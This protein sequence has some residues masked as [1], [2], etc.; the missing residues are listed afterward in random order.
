[1]QEAQRFLRYV[2]PGLILFIELIMYL[3]LSGDVCFN[4]LIE[5]G[6]NI[7]LAISAFLVTGAIG[8]LLGIIYNN[9]IWSELFAKYAIDHRPLLNEGKLKGWLKLQSGLADDDVDVNKLS[10]RRAWHIAISYWYTRIEMSNS[11]KGSVLRV[12]RLSDIVNGLGTQCISSLFALIIWGI[13]NL[14]DWPN[15]IGWFDLFSLAAGISLFVLHRE[16]FRN[17]AKDLGTIF[18]I[19]L[20]NDLKLQHEKNNKAVTLYVFNYEVQKK[21]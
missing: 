3:L 9:I 11:I 19:V 13:Y 15:R 1:M 8:F 14:R 6:D 20:L 17:V 5:L 12:E 2:L 16:N 7:W 10:A 21:K 18:G 4:Q